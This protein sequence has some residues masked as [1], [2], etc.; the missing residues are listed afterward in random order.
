MVHQL[1][2]FQQV[3]AIAHD[4]QALQLLE[5]PP[6]RLDLLRQTNPS[7]LPT[8]ESIATKIHH[9]GFFSDKTAELIFLSKG[10]GFRPELVGN[11]PAS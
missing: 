11:F 4:R 7:T 10:A 1:L 6:G 8:I 3:C 2:G 9:L 5:K